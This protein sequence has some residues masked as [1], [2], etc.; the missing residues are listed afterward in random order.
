MGAVGTLRPDMES[1]LF[2]PCVRIRRV[3]VF[4]VGFFDPAS[5]GCAEVFDGTARSLLERLSLEAS[6]S[7]FSSLN[8]AIQFEADHA[9]FLGVNA[10]GVS[11]CRFLLAARL[12][13]CRLLCSC[14][15]RRV[16]GIVDYG[17]S[18]GVEEVSISSVLCGL[19]A[20]GLAVVVAATGEAVVGFLGVK[21][22][23]LLQILGRM[24]RAD[25][26]ASF[27]AFAEEGEKGVEA[28]L[29]VEGCLKAFHFFV[30]VVE[31]QRCWVVKEVLDCEKGMGDG[32]DVARKLR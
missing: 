17:F 13:A 10:L 4:A 25:G 8:E 20:V 19:L 18:I 2:H 30:D 1:A 5:Y 3:E 14:F 12:F 15:R 31:V 21:T 29:D 27:V 16:C 9:L 24:F 11:A 23:L 6:T 26:A 32:V 28:C 22:K 7:T